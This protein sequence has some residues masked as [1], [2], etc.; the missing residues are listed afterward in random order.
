[1]DQVSWKITFAR[2]TSEMDIYIT[3]DTEVWPVHP[4]R[5]RTNHCRRATR[6]SSSLMRILS[7]LPRR[8]ALA[9]LINWRCW[10][11]MG[12]RRHISLTRSSFALGLGALK[13]VVSLIE[14][15]ASTSGFTS[16]PNGLRTSL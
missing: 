1:M 14:V 2:R 3:V 10:S 7:G 8:E 11:G 15:A 16:I 5:G 12:S 9:C 4:G 13:S 6:A